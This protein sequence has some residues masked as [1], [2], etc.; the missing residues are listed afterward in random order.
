MDPFQS[1]QPDEGYSEDPLSASG[2]LAVSTKATAGDSEGGLPQVL[3]RHISSLSVAS[4]IQL[5]EALLE[6]LPTSAIAQIV[7]KLS[8]RLYIDFIRFLPAEIC[9]NILGYLDPLSLI[10]VARSCRAWYGLALDRKLWERLYYLEGWKT[11]SSEL[12]KCEE[13]INRDRPAPHDEAGGGHTSKRRA[14]ASSRRAADGDRDHVMLDADRPWKSDMT[15][16]DSI[17]EGQASSSL[18]GNS[19][20]KDTSN[21]DPSAVTSF[22][23]ASTAA[24]SSSSASK[25]GKQRAT[26]PPP[27]PVPAR[28]ASPEGLPKPSLW[29]L[30]G[31]SGKY[32]MN[33]K[34][35]YTL[36]RRLEANWELGKYTNFQFPHPDYPNE[37]HGECIYTIQ[38]NQ[39][40]L[41]SGS[42]DRTIRIWN[43][44]TRRLARMPFVGHRGSVLCLQ[45]DSSPEEDLIVSGSSDS[46]VILWRFSTGEILQR[47]HR[48]HREPVLNVKFD[49]NILVTCSKD[50]TIKIFN[51]QPLK[52]GDLGYAVG[53]G[54]NGAPVNPVPIHLKNYGY[55]EDALARMPI[56][57]AYTMIGSLEGHSAAVNAVQIHGREII[58]ASG[59]R[60]VKIWDWPNQQCIRTLVGHS[61]GIACVQYDGRRIVSGSSDNEVKVFDRRTSLEVGSLRSHSNLVR[62]VQAGFGDLPY[63]A[64]EDEK[65]AARMDQRYLEAVQNGTLPVN[66]TNQRRRHR[67]SNRPNGS[68][69]AAAAVDDDD[70]DNGML[71]PE[72]IR[73]TGA[74]LPPGGGGG[75]YGRIVSG[76]YDTTIIIWRRNKHGM[77]KPQHHLK[78]EE[79][80]AAASATTSSATN[81]LRIARRQAAAAAA[82]VGDAG[83]QPL[84][85]AALGALQQQAAQQQSEQH[86]A[87]AAVQAAATALTQQ[88]TQQPSASSAT[89]QPSAMHVDL[90]DVGALSSSAAAAPATGPAAAPTPVQSQLARL[91]DDLI[92]QGVHALQQ[93]LSTYPDLLEMQPTLQAAIDRHPSPFVRSQLRQAVSTALVRAQ[94]AQAQN[95]GSGSAG[96]GRQTNPAAGPSSSTQATAGISAEGSSG[97]QAPP[98]AAT[99]SGAGE[100]WTGN[101]TAPPLSTV[102]APH[103]VSLAAIENHNQQQ[104][105]VPPAPP[106][107]NAS[108]NTVPP[109]PQA[110]AAAAAAAAAATATGAP[111]HHPHM[112]AA[113]AAAADDQANPA[114]VFKLQFDARRIICCSQTAIIVGWDFCNGDP[115]LEEAARFFGTIE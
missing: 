114:R 27:Q 94:M 107:V 76:S 23:S 5:T 41:V 21:L 60:N 54:K 66:P 78:Q 12:Q 57:P 64:E 24:S 22:S 20:E 10:S 71:R 17:P 25:K 112:H 28:E 51:R 39:D 56:R 68:S 115:E 11:I 35:L 81:A 74:K 59:D 1:Q 52:P 103:T 96:G 84:T 43:L 63:S 70:D 47:L 95:G 4:K 97:A 99:S 50:K 46:N 65:A 91:I 15:A 30:D 61:K 3:S 88:T 8:P 6:S 69:S 79:A 105:M 92:A 31:V 87:A 44:Q 55:D 111:P 89:P 19:N 7:Q 33:W 109:A 38:F 102:I 48:A 58:S 37:A 26:S 36:R 75:Q 40:Y 98:P 104:V 14:I 100:P 83:S 2:S 80:A 73:F 110:V 16:V 101:A 42:R 85:Q 113:A 67:S 45:F 53:D 77:W 62:T 108:A 32:R 9:L 29:V 106:A 18:F 49:K 90:P 93:A 13:T 34:H 82:A 86:A 72:N